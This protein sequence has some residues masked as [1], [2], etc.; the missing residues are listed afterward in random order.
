MKHFRMASTHEP[1]KETYQEFER[2]FAHFNKALFDGRLPR[3]L[4]TVQRKNRS[5]GYFSGDRWASRTGEVT[6]EIALNPAHFAEQGDEEVL[7]TLVHEM[8]HLWQ[9]HFGRPSRGGYHN[10]EWAY[11]MRDVGL[12]P[13]T[14]GHPGGA[15]TGQQVSHF[16][17]KGGRFEI[18]CA[19]ILERG[20]KVRWLDR[21]RNQ[22]FKGRSSGTRDRYTCVA[23]RLNAWARPGV[24]LICGK[25]S[26]R[27]LN[28]A[29]LAET[30]QTFVRAKKRLP[31]D[32]GEETA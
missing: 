15:A 10:K 24:S 30:P 3:C 7:S 20:F 28:S 12:I 18:A 29:E 2:A 14:T 8:C 22:P 1:T 23:C 21:A 11:K 16:I 4:I 13:S 5:L 9:H 6:D 25:C 17:E 19:K 32:H 31:T 27:M 26:K